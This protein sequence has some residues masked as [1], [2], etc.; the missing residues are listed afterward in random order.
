MTYTAE[1]KALSFFL[2]KDTLK[3]FDV[4]SSERDD[5]SLQITLEEMN[6]PPLTSR[7]DNLL[8]RSLGFKDIT[9][10]DFPA[11]GRETQLTF[12]RRR[13]QVGNE[14]LKREIRLSAPGTRLEEEFGRFLKEDS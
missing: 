11:R 6:Q 9:I 4:V 8:V 13:W 2:P 7:H 12:R 10:T 1:Q 3:Y 14:I 5:T